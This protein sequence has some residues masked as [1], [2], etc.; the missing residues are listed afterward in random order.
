MMEGIEEGTLS[1]ISRVV[2]VE[3]ENCQLREVQQAQ[4][5]SVRA[6]LP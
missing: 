3:E 6:T 5:E 1:L 2:L 4:E